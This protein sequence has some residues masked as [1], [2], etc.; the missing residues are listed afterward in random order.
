MAEERVTFRTDT[1]ARCPEEQQG[2]EHEHEAEQGEDG[3]G[4]QAEPVGHDAEI[5]EEDEL[6]LR[7]NLVD[8]L[9]ACQLEVE[10]DVLIAGVELQGTLEP[11]DAVGYVVGAIIGAAQVVA[12]V[13]REVLLC[14]LAIELDRRGIV[15]TGIGAV[16]LGLHHRQAVGCL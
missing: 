8:G 11:E 5:G 14:Q 12:N 6:V 10:E 4:A 16:G 3:P 1:L 7:D 13:G 2:G 15:G 9:C